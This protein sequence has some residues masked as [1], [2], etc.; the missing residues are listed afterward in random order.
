MVVT[1]FSRFTI[2]WETP[3]HIHAVVL[4]TPD[5][6]RCNTIFRIVQHLWRWQTSA[7]F[8]THKRHPQ[9]AL[10]HRYIYIYTYI[11]IYIHTQWY[12]GLLIKCGAIYHDIANSTTM[13]VT[14]FG[15]ISSSWKTPIAR[16]G[17]RAMSIFIQNSWWL[18]FRMAVFKF[19]EKNIHSPLIC[20]ILIFHSK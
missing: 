18:S 2:Q 1:N 13:K 4:R 7:R 5:N 16:P 10:T 11:Y 19:F 17:G 6:S 20:P 14:N 8:L 3:M 15:Q 12:Y 9:L